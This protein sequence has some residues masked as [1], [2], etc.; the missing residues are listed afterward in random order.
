[1]ERK[2]RYWDLFY[3][4]FKI[5]TFTIGGGYAMIPLMEEIIVDKRHWIGREEFMDILSVSQAMPGVFAVNMATNIGYRLKGVRGA[6]VAVMGNIIAPVAIIL[7]LAMFFHSFRENQVVEAIFKGLRPAVVGL[8]ASAALLL[9]TEENFGSP[10]GS[11]L[12][13]W[14]SAGLFVAAF[15]AMKFFKVSPIL[16]LLLAG[17]FGGVFYGVIA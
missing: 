6:V 5:G 3:S 9:M 2:V 12:Q 15:V 14:V 10:V 17:V 7:C 11:P 1:M 4:F 13:F 8:I 16:I